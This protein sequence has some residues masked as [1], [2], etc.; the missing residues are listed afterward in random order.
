MVDDGLE[1]E[2][3]KREKEWE[4]KCEERAERER[5]SF[6]QGKAGLRHRYVKLRNLSVFEFPEM[7]W[8]PM[9]NRKRGIVSALLPKPTKLPFKP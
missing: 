3:E 6:I 9:P 7:L 8:L 1:K 4:E 2:K 5:D